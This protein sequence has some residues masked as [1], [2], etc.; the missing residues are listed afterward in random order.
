MN[1]FIKKLSYDTKEAGLR[2]AFEKFG[3]IA[4]CNIVM[5]AVTKKSKRFGF[6]EMPNENEAKKA[7]AALNKSKLDGS[8]IAVK[9]TKPKEGR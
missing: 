4:N 7:I 2:A 3:T 1:I 8:I 9:E 5:D 6:V